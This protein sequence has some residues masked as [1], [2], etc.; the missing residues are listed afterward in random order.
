[1]SAFEYDRAKITLAGEGYAE[2][3]E[4]RSVFIAHAASVASESEAKRYI[5]GIKEKY[6]DASHNVYAYYLAGGIYA[7]YSDDGE[8]Q[9]T[10]GMPVLNV[11]KMSGADDICVVVTRYFGGTLLGAGGLVRAYGAAA[12]AAIDAAGIAEIAEFSVFRADMS[13]SEYQRLGSLFEKY[14]VKETGA[15]FT[16]RVSVIAMCESASFD[17]V[18][19]SLY[20]VTSGRVKAEP[21]G[22]KYAPKP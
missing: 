11:L 16:D 21:L 7:R 10:A 15:E 9:G 2:I 19:L 22:V 20:D 6:S 5:D 3:E 17:R 4:K 12:K 13:Y 14:G 1:M 18:A 8:P